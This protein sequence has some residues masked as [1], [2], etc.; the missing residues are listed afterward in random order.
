MRAVIPRDILAPFFVT[1]LINKMY[2]AVCSRGTTSWRRARRD[3]N[4]PVPNWYLY[5]AE[6]H[7]TGPIRNNLQRRINFI[8]RETGVYAA[9]TSFT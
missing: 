3:F 9:S 8:E 7:A 2:A 4:I 5:R 6:I 1:R